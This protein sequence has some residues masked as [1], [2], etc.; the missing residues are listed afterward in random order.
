MIQSYRSFPDEFQKSMLK[1]LSPVDLRVV[2]F[3][4]A[5]N[6]LRKYPTFKEVCVKCKL[7]NTSAVYRSV[8][9]LRYLG[10]LVNDRYGHRTLRV[11]V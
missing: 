7:N 1:K 4:H 9:R 3:V 6:L 11:V 8:K 2:K 10:L 5:K